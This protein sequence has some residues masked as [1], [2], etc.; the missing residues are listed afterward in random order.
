MQRFPTMSRPDKRRLMMELVQQGN[1]WAD[2]RAQ[3]DVWTDQ[4][5]VRDAGRLRRENRMYDEG[6]R[7]EEDGLGVMPQVRGAR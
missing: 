6:A 2:M 7:D 3:L 5:L 1:N 4:R